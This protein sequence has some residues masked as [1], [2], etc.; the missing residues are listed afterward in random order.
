MEEELSKAIFEEIRSQLRD[1]VAGYQLLLLE[2]QTPLFRNELLD[3]IKLH[4]EAVQRPDPTPAE[5]ERVLD[6]LG[7]LNNMDDRLR[8]HWKELQKSMGSR[9]LLLTN[10][11]H[12]QRSSGAWL[13]VDYTGKPAGR[14]YDWASGLVELIDNVSSS[15]VGSIDEDFKQYQ[16]TFVRPLK[17]MMLN[18]DHIETRLRAAATG[19][20][21]PAGEIFRLI[22][23]C[24]WTNLAAAVVNDRKLAVTLFG[25][26]Q[27]NNGCWSLQ[28]GKLVLQKIDRIGGKYFTELSTPSRYT[29][30]K[31]ARVLS[32]KKAA[33]V[34]RHSS[35]IPP[36]P[37][38]D[39]H[40][41]DSAA[42]AIAPKGVFDKVVSG[43]GLGRTGSGLRS[44]VRRGTL[45]TSPGASLD[46]TTQL[47]DTREKA[48]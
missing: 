24:D 36:S 12:Y 30:S 17:E 16:R 7:V 32:A 19:S 11:A 5:R 35:S 4:E 9:T 10:I 23:Q 40:G 21:H 42:A 8:G 37:A 39:R 29:L 20:T 2:Y 38:S 26:K 22:D 45:T 18:H 48:G 6:Q 27:L 31:R 34:A 1:R 3:A 44:I 43:L 13:M 46:S 15:G 25:A 47:V 14:L 41:E 33:H 28:F